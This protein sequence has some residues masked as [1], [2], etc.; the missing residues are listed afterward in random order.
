MKQETPMSRSMT[1][2]LFINAIA[3]Q[4]ALSS[5]ASAQGIDKGPETEAIRLAG[6]WS[7]RSFVSDPDLSK[8][9][10]GFGQGTLEIRLPEPNRL[11]GTLGGP[12]WTLDL[13]GQVSTS[14]NVSIRFQGKGIIG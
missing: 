1:A 11:S 5:V 13:N 2:V 14:G 4:G 6:K 3:F 7:Y 8:A 9:P 12:G 10:V